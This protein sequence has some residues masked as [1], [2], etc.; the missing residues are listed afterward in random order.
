MRFVADQHDGPR[1]YYRYRYLYSEH[2]WIPLETAF[3]FSNESRSFQKDFIST[4]QLWGGQTDNRYIG[5]FGIN[6]QILRT[7]LDSSGINTD[8]FSIGMKYFNLFLKT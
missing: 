7:P 8:V 5:I 2:L 6:T 3:V 4:Y 1:Q